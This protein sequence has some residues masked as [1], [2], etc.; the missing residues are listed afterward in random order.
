MNSRVSTVQFGSTTPNKVN[1]KYNEVGQ[2]ERIDWLDRSLFNFY[3]NQHRLIQQK[4]KGDG[5]EL[6]RS[7][8]YSGF[9]Y[10]VAVELNNGS[11]YQLNYEPGGRLQS[12]RTPLGNEHKFELKSD[13]DSD[14]ELVRTLP[15]GQHLKAVYNSDGQIS[16]FFANSTQRAQWTR[17]DFGRVINFNTSTTNFNIQY[18]I[19]KKES[20]VS[21]LLPR[22]RLKLFQET[23][24]HSDY[25]KFFVKQDR[26]CRVIKEGAENETRFSFTLYTYDDAGRIVQ[27]SQSLDNG[28]TLKFNTTYAYDFIGKLSSIGNAL[29]IR[30]D[31]SIQLVHPKV[32]FL[33]VVQKTSFQFELNFNYTP[34]RQLSGVTFTHPK[35]TISAKFAYNSLSLLN[36]SVWRVDGDV[37]EHGIFN[38]KDGRLSSFEDEYTGSETDQIDYTED[39][40]I[41]PT[42]EMKMETNEIGWI[43]SQEALSFT[44]DALGQLVRLV[45]KA[46]NSTFKYVY[47]E[48]QRLVQRRTDAVDQ[49]T[50]TFYYGLSNDPNSLS[51]FSFDSQTMYAI[52]YIDDRPVM[53][54][55][56]NEEETY[57]L[58]TDS[59]GSIR[60]IINET[61]IITVFD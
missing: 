41:K 14:S 37:I 46:T 29:I 59:Y 53:L 6:A 50:V 7:F 54:E 39:G 33:E 12:I 1:L 32:G 27:V 38:Y 25:S 35:K 42:V 18:R 15:S 11:E 51:R 8:R 45:D 47:N 4:I 26:M 3:D 17:N 23:R 60:Q 9:P 36:T 56:L 58:V 20:E 57:A 30:G 10:P 21:P 5:I 40:S 24:V 52:H 16:E 22:K 31:N 19:Y 13:S 55:N 43:V 2:L 34:D 48:K 49:K 61:G 44:Y 28:R